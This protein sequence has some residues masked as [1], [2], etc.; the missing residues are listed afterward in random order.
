MRLFSAV[1]ATI[2]AAGLL[3]VLGWG[4]SHPSSAST[5]RVGASAPA[6]TLELLDGS[7]LSLAAYHGRP[8]VVNFWATWCADCRK[9][10]PA[11]TSTARARQDVAFLGVLY[12]D[13]PGAAR[14]YQAG[15]TAYPYPVGWSDGSGK[16][17]GV[18]ANPETFFIDPRGVVRAIAIGPLTQAQ[19]N[20]DLG[21]AE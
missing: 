14:S 9:E 13:D 6:M 8:V 3:S 11:L 7:S 2:L 19:L 12:Q 17:F 21:K 5:V 1:G 10:A 4:L 20:A 15:A 18:Q 16:A